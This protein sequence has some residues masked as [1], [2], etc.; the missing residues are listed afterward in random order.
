MNQ[1]LGWLLLLYTHTKKNQVLSNY[2]R[3]AVDARALCGC[4]AA[5][6]GKVDMTE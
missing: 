3:L 2:D 5:S 1:A 6:M 4:C